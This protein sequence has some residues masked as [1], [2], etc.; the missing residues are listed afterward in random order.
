MPSRRA[1]SRTSL[2]ARLRLYVSFSQTDLRNANGCFLTSI[3]CVGHFSD[4]LAH[5]TSEA[6]FNLTSLFATGP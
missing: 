4:Y 1:K 2:V 5:V 3:G 6:P